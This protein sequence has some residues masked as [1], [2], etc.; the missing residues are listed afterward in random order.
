M[1]QHRSGIA[2]FA[3]GRVTLKTLPSEDSHEKIRKHFSIRD[4]AGAAATR[5]TPVEYVPSGDLG[6]RDK[7]KLVYD[8][9]TA[10]PKGF[11]PKVGGGLD[12]SSVTALPKGFAP[13]CN[14][15]HAL[16]AWHVGGK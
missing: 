16:G 5:Q 15:Y 7:W 2:I 3:D 14:Q 8:S 6:D 11:A 10:L 4:G 12:L 1:C 13:K 9:V